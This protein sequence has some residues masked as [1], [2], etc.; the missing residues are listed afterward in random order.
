MDENADKRG[1]K[2]MADITYCGKTY[3]KHTE[4]ERHIDNIPQ[5]LDDSFVPFAEFTECEF[6]ESEE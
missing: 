4:C 2:P 6:W 1:G 5:A 3:C